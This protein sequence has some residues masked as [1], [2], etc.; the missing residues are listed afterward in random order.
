MEDAEFEDRYL[1]FTMLDEQ[2]YL[3][4]V[5]G[6]ATEN[7]GIR[8]F[9]DVWK[10]SISF[11]DINDV[12]KACNVPIPSCG[13]GLRCYPNAGT[14][15]AADGSYVSCDACPHST[16]SASSSGVPPV[17]VALVVFVLLFV[18]TAGAL[19]YVLRRR[20]AAGGIGAPTWWQKSGTAGANDS[21]IGATDGY[22]RSD[23]GLGYVQA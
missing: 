15:V 17:V 12:S 1:Q 11:H 4:V 16:S 20:G 14:V 18:A 19:L 23:N 5:A 9:N 2:G 8:N 7:A 6:R 3:Y 10:S 13:V 22:A 21:L